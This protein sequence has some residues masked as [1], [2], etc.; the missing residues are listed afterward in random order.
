MQKNIKYIIF[1]LMLLLSL[2]GGFLLGRHSRV[3]NEPIVV[4]E[5]IRDTIRHYLPREIEYRVTRDTIVIHDTTFCKDTIFLPR[6]QK[7]Y[8]DSSYRAVVSGVSPRLDSIEVYQRTVEI[9]KVSTQKE[10]RR[11]TY[12]VQVGVGVV[13]P[14]NTTPTFGGYLGFGIGYNF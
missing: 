4:T 13:M 6:E 11:F 3:T 7:V 2:F 9:T 14:F 12:G 1:A 10:W 8:A 5:V